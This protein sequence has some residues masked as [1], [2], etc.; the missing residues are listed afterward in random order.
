MPNFQFLLRAVFGL[1]SLFVLTFFILF[2]VD[3]VLTSGTRE[4]QRQAN[5]TGVLFAHVMFGE[6]ALTIPALQSTELV[7]SD[8]PHTHSDIRR[9]RAVRGLSSDAPWSF[10]DSDVSGSPN[11]T[12]IRLQNGAIV[13]L[14]MNIGFSE[15]NNVS[16]VDIGFV[17]MVATEIEEITGPP[18]LFVT[19]PSRT[20]SQLSERL[21]T[22]GWVNGTHAIS[23]SCLETRM[24]PETFKCSYRIL[25]R[26]DALE[27]SFVGVT[28]Q[29]RPE[30]GERNPLLV[31]DLLSK[32]DASLD[33]YA[34]LETHLE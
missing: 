9:A 14:A 24:S 30:L 25:R 29:D 32:F 2:S 4:A 1:S 15:D 19:D 33:Y 22:A 5:C 26:R 10:C 17:P 13:P 23:T 27:I 3:F 12:D 18:N 6:A 20:P 34:A 11:V 16:L 31:N 8:P 7:I 28:V 21:R